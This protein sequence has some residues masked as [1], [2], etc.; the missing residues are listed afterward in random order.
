MSSAA[1][2]VSARGVSA[3]VVAS[4]LFG[5]LF[6][7]PPLL[8][9]L[10]ANEVL[11]WR[12]IATIPVV[13]VLLLATRLW[14]DVVRVAGLL[15]AR[16]RLVPVLLLD[17]ALLAL[18]LWLF[19]WAPQSGHGLDLALGYLLMPLVM[20]VLGVV[21]HRERITALRGG[22]VLAAV[23][24]VTAAVIA[25]GGI[26]WATVAVAA[27]YPLYFTIRRRAGLD[28]VG[29]LWFELLVILPVALWFALQPASIATIAENPAIGWSIPLLGV[30]SGAALILY[31]VASTE[32]PFGI[33]GLLSYLEPVLLVVVSVALLGEL[34][35][36]TDAFVYG[37]IALAL[38]L[39]GV[40]GLRRPKAG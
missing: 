9:P 6:F 14:S 35:T 31:L 22:A 3:S 26:S 4:V 23:V 36:A 27:G 7:I 12:V 33:F 21:L 32:L 25:A 17:G 2:P 5:V 8:A 18:Q 38:L 19:G 34:F 15:R 30:V 11:G 13:T 20:V 39:L 1:R 40:E 37:P 10:D 29:A 24:G 16:L 28:S